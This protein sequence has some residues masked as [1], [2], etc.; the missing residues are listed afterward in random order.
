ML[1]EHPDGITA[2]GRASLTRRERREAIDARGA[3]GGP[4]ISRVG[5]AGRNPLTQ[6]M[7]IYL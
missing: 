1:R 3:N 6:S 4:T 5:G 2:C 7:C